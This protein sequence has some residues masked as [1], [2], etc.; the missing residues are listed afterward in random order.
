MTANVVKKNSLNEN[1]RC[2]NVITADSLSEGRRA[3]SLSC[4]TQFDNNIVSLEHF[5]GA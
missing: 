5:K 4:L 2:N 1:G 3:L